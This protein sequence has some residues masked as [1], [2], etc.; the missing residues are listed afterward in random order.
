MNLFQDWVSTLFW[1]IDHIDNTTFQVSQ[2]GD[3]LHLNCV[4]F[5]KI[6]VQNSWRIY[7][8]ISKIVMFSVP[9]VE[10]FSCEGIRLNLYIGSADTVNKTWFSD[11]RIASNENSSF[12]GIDG[13]QTCHMFPHFLQIGKWRS[14][15]SDHCAHS[16]QSCSF[17]GFATI[18]RIS[19]FYQFKIISTHVFNHIFCCLDVSEC[20]LVMVLIIEDIKKISV[21]W[22]DVFNFGEVVKDVN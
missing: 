17:E 4:H 14:Y 20:Q 9:D 6:V 7:N 21:K 5:L 16:T 11:I 22:M 12:I 13:R 1:R 15:F 19:I 3:R 2:S 8:L 10:C 18:E